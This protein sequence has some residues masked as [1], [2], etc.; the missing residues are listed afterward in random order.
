MRIGTPPSTDPNDFAFSHRVRVRFSETDA[1]GVVHHS[2]YLPY[3]EEARVAYLRAVGHSYQETRAQG[4]DFAIIE[5][6]VG[7]LSPLRFDDEV[8]IHLRLTHLTPAT[9]QMHYLLTVNSKTC[10]TAITA[11]TAVNKE[12]RPKRLPDWLREFVDG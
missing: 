1:M 3:L 6:W 11:H 9:F 2:R 8:D 4:T 10:A 5:M 12:G 7:Y